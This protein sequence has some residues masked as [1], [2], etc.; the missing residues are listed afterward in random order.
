MIKKE[1]KRKNEK[2]AQCFAQVNKMVQN[3]DSRSLLTVMLH[4]VLLGII[5]VLSTFGNLLVC[6][7]FYKNRRLR[8]IT[9][10]YV[11]SLAVADLTVAIFAFPSVIVASGL[12]KWPFS[13]GSCQFSGFVTSYLFMVSLCI[14]ALTSINRYFCVV[15]PQRYSYFF[16]R[17][18]TI[19]SIFYVWIVMFI[20]YLTFYFAM[21]TRFK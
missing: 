21:Q 12:R 6:L 8:S 14:L 1:K 11:L 18:K 13:D 17:K 4:T 7:A 15:K 9:N 5:F 2:K 3:K 16:N 19:L 10:F 20:F